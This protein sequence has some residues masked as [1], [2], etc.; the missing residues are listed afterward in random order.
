MAK[1]FY[2]IS[3][4]E[5]RCSKCKR[6]LPAARYNLANWLPSGLRSDCKDCY[7]E[8]KAKWYA[9]QPKCPEAAR[10]AELKQLASA[11][12]R[13]CRTCKVVKP[14]NTDN[15]GLSNK[16]WN[17]S[18]RECVAANAKAWYAANLDYAKGV[19]VARCAERYASKRQRTPYWL[20]KADRER[21]KDIYLSCRKLTQ[22]TGIRHHV[23]HIVPL[24]GKYVSGLH[25]PGNLQ[26][27]LG[28]ENC[29]KSNKWSF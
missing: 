19:S 1:K 16:W 15:F 28:S 6:I 2:T 26:I 22:D 25:T 20:S 21:I 17:S 24:M 12:L 13:S 14:L 11:G 27:L 9:A 29:R 7:R 8:T 5:K 3:A 10:A 4:T 23:D 18:C